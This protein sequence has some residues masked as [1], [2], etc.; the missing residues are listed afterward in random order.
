[1]RI[2]SGAESERMS[3]GKEAERKTIIFL[4]VRGK[5]ETTI[6]RERE[7]LREKDIIRQRP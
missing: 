5:K 4:K 3:R 7:R 6:E 1:M 2:R